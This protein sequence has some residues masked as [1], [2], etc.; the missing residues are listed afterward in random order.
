MRY[1]LDLSM[2]AS[3]AAI[4]IDKYLRQKA[5]QEE[6][7]NIDRL[8]KKLYGIR[9]SYEPLSDLMM[10]DVIWPNRR[11]WKGKKVGDTKL[12]TWLFAKDL[13]TLKDLSIGRQQE[14]KEACLDLS[15]TARRSSRPFFGL[16][17]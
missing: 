6:Y 3:L 11:D 10:A 2:D 1:Y 17:A 4:A 8:S 16:A 14:L 9:D 12:H 15:R 5:T 13:S 7:E